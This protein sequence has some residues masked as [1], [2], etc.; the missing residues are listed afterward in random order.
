MHNNLKIC[1]AC[2]ISMPC[3]DSF[4]LRKAS[5]KKTPD[6]LRNCLSSGNIDRALIIIAH[7]ARPDATT[8]F[9][10]PAKQGWGWEGSSE[11]SGGSRAS[12]S[13][14]PRSLLLL[15]PPPSARG[16]LSL[17]TPECRESWLQVKAGTKTIAHGPPHPILRNTQV[18][19][20]QRAML[21]WT[22]LSSA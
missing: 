6:S 8:Q 14:P 3:P 19:W 21:K 18:P 2:T 11:E 1:L 12:R 10:C 17:P 7:H 4:I 16:C 9:L 22:L 15:W 13:N 5:K 20:R